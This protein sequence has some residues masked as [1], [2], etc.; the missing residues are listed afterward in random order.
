MCIAS[1]AR[2]RVLAKLQHKSP[3]LQRQAVEEASILLSVENLHSFPF[4]DRRI[5]EGKLSLHAWYFDLTKGE[6]LEY[7]AERGGFMRLGE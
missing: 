1:P 6:L 5:K 7:V 3:E 2:E 4:I